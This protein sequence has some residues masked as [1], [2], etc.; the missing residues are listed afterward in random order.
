MHMFKVGANLFSF[1]HRQCIIWDKLSIAARDSKDSSDSSSSSPAA[2]DVAVRCKPLRKIK[3]A[4][5]STISCVVHPE[6]YLDKIIVGTVEGH[7]DLYNVRLGRLVHRF[8]PFVDHRHKSDADNMKNLRALLSKSG[9]ED[10]DNTS[11]GVSVTVLES[12]GALDVVAIGLSNGTILLH[13]IKLDRTLFSFKHSPGPVTSISFRKGLCCVG[14]CFFLVF[15]PQGCPH[16]HSHSHLHICIIHSDG[17][18]LMVSGNEK[19]EVAVWN[20]LTQT[21]VSKFMAHSQA[22]RTLFFFPDESNLLTSG[23]DNHMQV[24]TFHAEEHHTRKFYMAG[25]Y[26][27]PRRVR[28]YDPLGTWL[29]TAGGHDRQV[30]L[31]SVDG[32]I[33]HEISQIKAKKLRRIRG[34]HSDFTR[35]KLNMPAVQDL[36]TC[37][38]RQDE[39]NTMVT[40][41][42][43]SGVARLWNVKNKSVDN[44]PLKS[45]NSGHVTCVAMSMCGN[46]CFL[47]GNQ[48]IEKWNV[49]S[50][51]LKQIFRPQQ[52]QQA[53]PSSFVGLVVDNTNAKIA[54]GEVN[55]VL[56]F[57]DLTS[58]DVISEHQLG[59]PI[60]RMVKSYDTSNL[61]AVACDDF[62]VRLFDM[63]T[64]RLIR[65]LRNNRLPSTGL[66]NDMAFSHDSRDV[67]C[68]DTMGNIIT[69]DIISANR[70]DWIK[71]DDPAVSIAFH[72]QG[73]YLASLHANSI[74]V[75]L[76]INKLRFGGTALQNVIEPVRLATPSAG[77]I[78]IE[79]E[80]IDDALGVINT[81][82]KLIKSSTGEDLSIEDEKRNDSSDDEDDD[83][84]DEVDDSDEYS[85]DSSSDDDSSSDSDYSTV[86]AID[87][88]LA[89][90]K[91]SS[92]DTIGSRLIALS[93]LPKHRWHT[94]SNLDLIRKRNKPKT[95]RRKLIAPFLLTTELSGD[96]PKFIKNEVEQVEDDGDGVESDGTLKTA[97]ETTAN[98]SRILNLTDIEAGTSSVLL[99]SSSDLVDFV[100]ADMAAGQDDYSSTITYLR[101]Q[102]TPKMIDVSIRT[103]SAANRFEELKLMLRFFIRQLDPSHRGNFD[104]VQAML[105]LFL[106][107]HAEVLSNGDAELFSLLRQ[108]SKLQQDVWQ[109]LDNMFQN[110]MFFA[111]YLNHL[112]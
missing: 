89:K 63:N 23:A 49:Q 79:T 97:A 110:N 62:N 68:C 94:I 13:N 75:S 73:L 42:A 91:R 3:L 22:I 93:G 34:K 84:S 18:P 7:V 44:T 99:P 5:D 17:E 65:V 38:L 52:P 101:D 72:P 36:D 50:K 83:S 109:R 105:H 78:V 35:D 66:I 4:A 11:S 100:K 29:L 98:F 31:T 2:A 82:S 70:I 67:V 45:T 56:C 111:K 57:W 87:E 51:T 26:S 12:S 39:W 60:T 43:H 77:E 46:F 41:H 19:G 71:V 108:L 6:T 9:E 74:G 33:S 107:V 24:L 85:S 16:L 21:I 47:G 27:P 69:Y 112:Q 102:A 14:L 28:F 96:T 20:L 48:F 37:F 32:D 53:K 59:S 95:A 80:I 90:R 55:G 1:S 40:C 8:D 88:P 25:H 15:F 81:R 103:L 58:G 86:A 61:L 54:S 10:G 104:L 106:Q 64:C 30:R 76:W 92:H